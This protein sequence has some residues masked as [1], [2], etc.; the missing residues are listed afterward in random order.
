MSIV[1]LNVLVT[2]TS[3]FQSGFPIKLLQNLSALHASY[4][5][6]W[7]LTLTIIIVT[8]NYF[9]VF[10]FD[11][12]KPTWL[13]ELPFAIQQDVPFFHPFFS[14]SRSAFMTGRRKNVKLRKRRNMLKVQDEMVWKIM[15]MDDRI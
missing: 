4:I 1:S 2:Y 10:S 9:N 5:S 6:G 13:G 15:K 3:F 14:L 11:I 8:S 7:H 12:L